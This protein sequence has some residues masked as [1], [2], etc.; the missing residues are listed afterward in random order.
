MA[1]IPRVQWEVDM[2]GVRNQEKLARYLGERK[3]HTRIT[4]AQRK[5]LTQTV[6]KS[7]RRLI[8]SKGLIHTGLML[9]AGTRVI[10]PRGQHR[11]NYGPWAIFQISGDYGYKSL[12]LEEGTN[13]DG[14]RKTKSIPPKNRGNITKSIHK[15]LMRQTFAE[16]RGIITPL[17]AKEFS[18]I[19]QQEIKK[20]NIR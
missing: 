6:L 17:F 8:R 3:F 15:N 12:F 7:A 5:V 2:R 10:V 4:R 1:R 13:V 20:F 9:N 19:I 16:N 18:K 11:N 14:G